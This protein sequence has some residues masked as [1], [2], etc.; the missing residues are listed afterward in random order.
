MFFLQWCGAT[1]VPFCHNI[2]NVCWSLLTSMICLRM[3]DVFWTG[4]RIRKMLTWNWAWVRV[5]ETANPADN[6]TTG[7]GTC[8]FEDRTLAAFQPANQ[9]TAWRPGSEVC[10]RHRFGALDFVPHI[11]DIKKHESINKGWRLSVRLLETFWLLKCCA[12]W[13]HKCRNM[14]QCCNTAQFIYH[15]K[16]S[17]HFVSRGSSQY[18][19]PM[20]LE[21]NMQPISLDSASQFD[22]RWFCFA[23]IS[24]S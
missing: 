8:F 23:F 13:D 15:S 24:H 5:W 18:D 16:I 21:L 17:L 6:R 19:G 1:G 4:G 7:H 12:G 2:R 11:I 20:L 10:K 3:F 22:I 14:L 9:L